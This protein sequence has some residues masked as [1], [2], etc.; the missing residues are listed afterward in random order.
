MT[1]AGGARGSEVQA[2]ARGAGAAPIDA[3]GRTLV[4]VT[5]MTQSLH[6]APGAKHV[7]LAGS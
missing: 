5:S 7:S 4:S 3:G 2:G 6:V 1:A